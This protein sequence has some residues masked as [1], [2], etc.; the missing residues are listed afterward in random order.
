[1]KSVLLVSKCGSGKSLCFI[2]PA[3][4]HRKTLGKMTIV[5]EPSVALIQE[6]VETLKKK[7]IDAISLGRPASNKRESNFNR[8]KDGSNLPTLAYCTPEYLLSNPSVLEHVC[9]ITIDEVHKMLDRR[10]GFRD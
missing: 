3:I 6:Q 9:L 8:L 7:D 10:E 4:Y 5:V 2:V 1:M